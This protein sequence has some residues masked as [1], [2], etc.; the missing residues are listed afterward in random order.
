MVSSTILLV[1]ARLL[2]FRAG[3]SMDG[4]CSLP[5]LTLTPFRGLPFGFLGATLMTTRSGVSRVVSSLNL[6]TGVP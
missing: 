5:L 6:R 1:A 4:T 3:P 2:V